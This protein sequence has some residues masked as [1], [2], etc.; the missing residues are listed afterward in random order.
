MEIVSMVLAGK[1]IVNDDHIP[2]ITS[3]ASDEFGQQYN[4]NADTLAGELATTLGGE[5]LILLT[6]V[7]GILEDRDNPSSLVKEV[8][9]R[10][11]KQMMEEGKI[12]GGMIPKY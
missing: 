11:V 1:S 12:G 3:V 7:V 5:K 2:V 6:D 8:D 10:R 9:I 4:I